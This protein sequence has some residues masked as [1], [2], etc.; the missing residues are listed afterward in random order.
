M[1]GAL[2]GLANLG[3][4][5]YMNAVLQ[6]L[7]AVP[8]FFEDL[9]SSTWCSQMLADV[10]Q[11]LDKVSSPD[12]SAW[13]SKEKGATYEV[14]EPRLCTALLRVI[15]LYKRKDHGVIDPSAVKKVST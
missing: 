7:F 12:S 9:L 8:S 14:M 13:K 3:N 6:S 5:C 2:E 15:L 1:Q 4:T 11:L 10:K